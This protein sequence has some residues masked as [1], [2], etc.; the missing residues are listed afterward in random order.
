MS[1]VGRF[2]FEDPVVRLNPIISSTLGGTKGN[3]TVLF[4]TF[5]SKIVSY[6]VRRRLTH[7]YPF[8]IKSLD[9]IIVLELITM[10]HSPYQK[11]VY[12]PLCDIDS[13]TEGLADHR[14]RTDEYERDEYLFELGDNL[15]NQWDFLENKLAIKVYLHF[16]QGTIPILV[17]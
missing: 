10:P 3:V 14:A 8:L 4:L 2:F 7:Q 13:W 16:R 6:S 15:L 11:T 17:D 12:Q 1:T 5:W 9:L